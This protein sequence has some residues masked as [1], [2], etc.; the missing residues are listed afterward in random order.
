[1]VHAEIV[2]EDVLHDD[3]DKPYLV[4]TLSMRLGM[5]KW[6]IRRKYGAFRN[7]EMLLRANYAE[8]SLIGLGTTP[9]P[10]DAG[11]TEREHE[12]VLEFRNRLCAS[13]LLLDTSPTRQFLEIPV[14]RSMLDLSNDSSRSIL[15]TPLAGLLLQGLEV[16]LPPWVPPRTDLVDV[17]A[18]AVILVTCVPVFV[19]APAL[20]QPPAASLVAVVGSWYLYQKGGLADELLAFVWGRDNVPYARDFVRPADMPIVWMSL[21]VVYG[22]GLAAESDFI[23]A[24]ALGFSRLVALWSA[25]N[26][27]FLATKPGPKPGKVGKSPPTAP[28]A[29][30]A[31]L[32]AT[33]SQ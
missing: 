19:G 5:K 23:Y 28:V 7:L 2:K 22:L 10:K 26:A 25:A 17:I 18:C 11:S 3:E 33:A 8:S 21:G 13:T 4:F 20:L 30:G 16:K 32:A 1:M 15:S 6:Q 24:T 31:P 27:V 9:L 29:S 14:S 12:L